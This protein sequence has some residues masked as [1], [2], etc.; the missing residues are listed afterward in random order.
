MTD[1]G[2]RE[3]YRGAQPYVDNCAACHRTNGAGA[4]DVFPAIAGNSSVLAADPASIVRLIL[5]GSALPATN[6]VP[7]TLGM[8]GFGW[9]LSDQEVA[10]LATET[11]A[12]ISFAVTVEGELR[13]IR[14]GCFDLALV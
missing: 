7:S 2:G 4:T 9:R 12:S 13:Q 10:E 6:A 14:G 5:Q 8:P 1:R 11:I 3:V